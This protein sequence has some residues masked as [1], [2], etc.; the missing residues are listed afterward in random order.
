ML[1][2]SPKLYDAENLDDPRMY[3]TDGNE[4]GCKYIR[5]VGLTIDCVKIQKWIFGYLLSIQLQSEGRI[6]NVVFVKHNFSRKIHN[7]NPHNNLYYI[8]N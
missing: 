7:R 5:E 4:F 3:V 1:R 6:L 2:F 8:R